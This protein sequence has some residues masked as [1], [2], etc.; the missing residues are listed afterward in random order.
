MSESLVTTQGNGEASAEVSSWGRYPRVRQEVRELQWRSEPLGAPSSER[1][2]L[3]YG[4]GR[5]YGDGCLNEGGTLL[6]TERLDRIVSFDPETGVL[7][8]EAGLTLYDLLHFAVPKGWFLPVSP[9]TQFVSLGGAVANDIHGKNH[10]RAGTFGRH[11]LGIELERSEEGRISC[12]PEHESELF[13]ATVAGLGLTGLMRTV[14]VQLK[15]IESPYFDVETVKFDRVEEFFELARESDREYEYT[16]AWIDCIHS[17][18]HI[19]RG[20]FMRGNHSAAQSPQEL[21]HVASPARLRVPFSFPRFAL[22]RYSLGLFNT[23]YYQKQRE[24]VKKSR[25]HY[26]PF[27]YPLDAVHHWNRIYGTRGFLQFQC[28]VPCEG[29]IIPI[30]RILERVVRYGKAS[31]LA[32]IKEFGDLPSPGMLSFPRPGVTLCL[33]F[34]MDGARTLQLFSELEALVLEYGGAMYPAKDACMTGKAFQ[35]FFPEWRTFA[36]FRDPQFSSSFWRRVTDGVID[37][38]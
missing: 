36:A 29:D 24:K 27:F 38:R 23:C 15:K 25:E 32:V 37:E 22:N 13:R 16:V 31:F 19:G 35:Q 6:A 9:G 11:V 33:D 30:R 1:T 26:R 7:E 3:P 4:Q 2:V 8:A 34:P 10:H 21:Q 17:T 20:L 12:G 14:T 5:T 28:V 18:P